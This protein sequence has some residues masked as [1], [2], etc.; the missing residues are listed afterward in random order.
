MVLT[1]ITNQTLIEFPCDFPLKI[2][3]SNAIDFISNIMT[4]V[5]KHFVDTPDNNFIHKESARGN[6]I[7]LTVTVYTYNQSSLDSLYHEL[8]QYP[9]IKMVL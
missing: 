3:G 9:G 8:I 1:M 5:R 2:I 6:Y 4:I 7:S